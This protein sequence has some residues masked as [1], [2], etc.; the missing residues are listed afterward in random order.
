MDRTSVGSAVRA[1][2][3][4]FYFNSVRFVAANVAWALCV[5]AVL[6]ATAIWTPALLLVALLAAPLA[7]LHRMAALLARDEP[8]SLEDFVSGIRRYGAQASG[9]AASA[10]GIGAILV[11]N[12]AIGFSS[13]GPL[14]WFLG[15]TAIYGLVALVMYLVAAWPVLVDPRR[16][17]QRL[18]RKLQVAGLV[19]IGRPG[20]LLLVTALVLL[21]LAASTV[22][23]AGIALFGVAFASIVAT[24][25][26]LPTADELETL[27]EAARAR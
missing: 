16:D 7:G 10:A 24:R 6:F 8:A 18:Q 2:A 25:W 23:L 27:F 12:V 22:L 5:L 13:D 4:D 26:V 19:V 15:A 17:G 21:I 11:T 20:R 9:V 1:A 3:T 14:G